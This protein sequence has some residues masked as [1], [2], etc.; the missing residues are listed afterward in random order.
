MAVNPTEAQIEATLA[1]LDAV[2][3][4]NVVGAYLYGS[5][6]DGGLRPAS[7]LDLLVV[8]AQPTTRD[9]RRRLAA[10]LL[11]ISRRGLR[12]PEWRPLEVTV[13][14]QADV[15]PLRV[16]PRTDFQ[17]GEWLRGALDAGEVDPAEPHNPDLLILLAQV[18]RNGR[19]LRGPAPAE[20]IDE[21]PADALRPGMLAALDPLLRD[22]DDDTTNV[23]LTLARMWRTLTTGDFVPK[24]A[25]AAWAAAQL[26]ADTARALEHAADVYRG[27]AQE[28]WSEHDYRTVA[29]VLAG[30]IGRG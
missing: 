3:G 19:P 18:R 28:S 11:P 24:D 23:L 2:L 1:V 21:V 17:Y 12:P 26:P 22:L 13:V 6:V 29:Q 20:V 9:E 4:A 16:A 5:A 15:M 14:E 30:E 8:V 7:D 27:V 10:G 25:A